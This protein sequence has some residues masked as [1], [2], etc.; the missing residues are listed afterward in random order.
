MLLRVQFWLTQEQLKVHEFLKFQQ[1]EKQ[2][3]K[4]MEKQERYE[5]QKQQELDAE[6][7]GVCATTAQQNAYRSFLRTHCGTSCANFNYMRLTL[8]RAYFQEYKR[9]QEVELRNR[10]ELCK[11]QQDLLIQQMEERKHNK[12]IL[13]CRR[14][15]ARMITTANANALVPV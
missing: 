13:V 7:R 3:Q 14:P 4:R 2:R 1:E 9:K 10:R 12:D 15:V 8:R 11:R 5:I 6:V